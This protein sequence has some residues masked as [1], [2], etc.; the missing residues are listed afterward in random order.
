LAFSFADFFAYL[1]VF[2]TKGTLGVSD[3]DYPQ[4]VQ[5]F[6]LASFPH[7]F[8]TFL[9]ILAISI[10]TL[11]TFLFFLT[12][13]MEMNGNFSELSSFLRMDKDKV[14]KQARIAALPKQALFWSF[15]APVIFVIL[16]FFEAKYG[17]PG[18]GSTIKIALYHGDFSLF[19]GSSCV[20]FMF[21]FAVNIFFLALKNI[22]PG[23]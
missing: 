19:Y 7:S 6:I 3:F 16:L 1:K 4:T 15:L 11:G 12:A 14:I 13:K 2:F 23:K 21:I 8:Y 18:L 9:F 10:C 22:L 17:I 20:A 5:Y